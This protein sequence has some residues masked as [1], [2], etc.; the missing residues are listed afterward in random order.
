MLYVLQHTSH[1]FWGKRVFPKKKANTHE[2][3]AIKKKT[4]AGLGITEESALPALL[5]NLGCEMSDIDFVV[6][7]HFHRD[8]TVTHFVCANRIYGIQKNKKQKNKKNQGK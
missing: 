1:C 7:S 8:H 6:H 2:T 4:G 3:Y 5:S